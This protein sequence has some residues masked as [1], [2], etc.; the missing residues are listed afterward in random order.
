MMDNIL[1]CTYSSRLVYF[2]SR[3][4]TIAILLSTYIEPYSSRPFT[5]QKQVQAHSR[6]KI[7]PS[8]LVSKQNATQYTDLI[9]LSIT[10]FLYF[11][12]VSL[13]AG[14]PA[15]TSKDIWEKY[16]AA[17]NS[18]HYSSLTDTQHGLSSRK[19]KPGNVGAEINFGRELDGETFCAAN[20]A[21]PTQYTLTIFDK[22]EPSQMAPRMWLFD[23]KCKVIGINLEAP[24]AQLE[25]AAGYSLSSEKPW[26]VVIHYVRKDIEITQD[27]SWMYHGQRTSPSVFS[28]KAALWLALS[29]SLLLIGMVAYARFVNGI[30]FSSLLER[31]IFVYITISLLSMQNFAL[32]S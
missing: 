25:S 19:V 28:A 17:Y 13:A 22:D 3:V 30:K 6:N 20:P 32:F 24:R 9:M 12:L 16:T 1:V 23:N 11:I 18:S 7:H 29:K 10:T 26:Y 15:T 5:H 27:F 4:L 31:F 2:M 8:Q 21:D 14:S